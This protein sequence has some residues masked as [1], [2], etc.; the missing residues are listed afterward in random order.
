MTRFET[1]WSI[2][3][4]KGFA[5]SQTFP[6][7]NTPTFLKSSHTSYLPAYEDGTEYSETSVYNSD[8]GELP[9]RKHTTT[10]CLLSDSFSAPFD[11]HNQLQVS[12][13]HIGRIGNIPVS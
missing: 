3:T 6:R 7:I 5:R 8:A 12:H 4:G 11:T 2:Y 1:S 9:G 10:E 13:T